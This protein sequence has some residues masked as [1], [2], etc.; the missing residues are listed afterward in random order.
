MTTTDVR[1]ES[2]LRQGFELYKNNAMTLILASLIAL[3]VSAITAGILGGPMFAGLV[4]IALRLYDGETPPPEAGDVFKGFDVF[5]SA[6]LF[7][8][9]WGLIA[10]AAQVIPGTIVPGIG[11]IAGIV[12]ALSA[13][14]AV[15]FG[16]FLIV[17]KR[18]E[19]WPA[20]MASFET[21]K[22]N[23]FPFL[24]FYIAVG[25]IGVLGSVLCGIGVIFT[26]PIMLCTLTVAYRDV[27][28]AASASSEAIEAPPPAPP[29]ADP[30]GP[31]AGDDATDAPQGGS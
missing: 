2:W 7:N 11:H 30:D 4:I 19:F 3:V 17:E 21:V 8:L 10:I 29:P 1:I 18:M 12:V 28:S 24:A 23:F 27:F 6:F 25:F 31:E 15:M 22:A 9:V 13:T 20:S 5:L 26:F 14:A 16:M